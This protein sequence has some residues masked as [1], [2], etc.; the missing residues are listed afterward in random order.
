MAITQRKATEHHEQTLGKWREQIAADYS[1]APSDSELSAAAENVTSAREALER[2]TLIRLAKQKQSE[3]A[4][5]INAASGHREVAQELRDAAK[6]T[7]EVLSGVVARTGCALRVEAGRMVLD[8]GRGTTY[9]GELSQGE[10]WRLALDV[11]IDAVGER[12]VL[13]IPQEAW[14]SLD[15]INRSMIAEHVA[16]RGV[17]VLTAEASEDEEI[18][19]EILEV[20]HD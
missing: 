2:G 13:T 1:I 6:G 5:H 9:F 4:G 7:D 16:G 18:R 10:R 17:V 12:G 15:P 11:A 20:N 8:T 19:S 14:E 3:A